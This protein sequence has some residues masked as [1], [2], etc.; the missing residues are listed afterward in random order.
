M[1]LQRERGSTLLAIPHN[2]NASDGRMFETRQVRRTAHRRRIQ[3]GSCRPTSRSTRSPR[4]RVRPRRIPTLSPTDEFANFEQWDYTLSADFERPTKRA[5]SFVRKALLDGLSQER[6]GQGNPFKYGFIGDSDTHN[7]AGNDEEFNYTGK[8]AFE[9]DPK[10]R[11]MGL[12]G[13]PP[14]QLRQIQEFSTGGLAGVW[15]EAKHARSDF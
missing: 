4:S 2:G 5:G 8:F 1:G 3:R 14:Q 10:D 6:A 7:A 12:E 9:N 13:Q 11:I 15:A